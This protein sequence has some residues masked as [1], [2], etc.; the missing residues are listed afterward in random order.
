MKLDE[1][2][3]AHCHAR[4]R[5][6]LAEVRTIREEMGRTEDV[7]QPPTVTGALPRECYFEA[8]VVWRKAARLAAELGV[9]VSQGVPGAPGLRDVRPGH[10]LQVIDGALA[11]IDAVRQRLA[12]P[13]PAPEPA[14]EP[15]REPSDVL[16]TL[17]RINRDL[18]RAL[19][20]PFTPSD[21]YRTVALASAYAARLGAQPRPAAF[22]RRRQPVHCYERLEA[23]LAR[24]STLIAARGGSALAVRGAPA[25]V[26]PG[27][28]YDLANLVLGEVAYLHALTSDAAPVHAFEP[29]PGGHR[30]PSHV[31][32]LA[33]TLDAQLAAL[34]S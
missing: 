9:E 20:R 11:Q 26:L 3:P 7:R 15:A 16:V 12:I 6:L 27:D 31:Y 25:D 33:S 30:L 18:S 4:A 13:E 8:I 19:E 34:A 28:V 32:Q 1:I 23:C 17:I 10:V 22:E 2:Q 14:I 21:V 24:A 5:R 29:E